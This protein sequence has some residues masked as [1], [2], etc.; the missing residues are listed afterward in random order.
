MTS[1]RKKDPLINNSGVILHQ[2]IAEIPE[3][4]RHL[5]GSAR[6]EWNE[7][8]SYLTQM[9]L[10]TSIDF[11]II[12]M[13]CNEVAMYDQAMKYLNES[14]VSLAPNG[15]EVPSPWIAIKNQSI[16]NIIKISSEYGFTPAARA[17]LKLGGKK[18]TGRDNLDNLLGG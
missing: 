14:T 8:W 1:G 16:A 2:A 18:V 5:Q 6:Q 3:C 12:I 17:K 9:Q 7:V 11:S 13:Y 4:P 10:G 15:Y